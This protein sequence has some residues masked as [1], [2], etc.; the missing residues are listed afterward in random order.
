MKGI[1]FAILTAVLWGTV[2]VMEKI[3]L[4]ANMGIYNFV[5]LRSLT[6]GIFALFLSFFTDF[7]KELHQ[8]P[9][10][11]LFLITGSGIIAG[12]IAMFIYYNALKRVEASIAVPV[13]STYPLFSL[14][15]SVI[16]LG[17][18]L[19]LQ[20]TIGAFFIVAG[21]IVLSLR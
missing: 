14:I 19:T 9:L 8:L 17:E 15:F 18:K 20:N 2:P 11:N 7:L 5:I 10:K 4:S 12:F 1:I 21:V 13:A 3:A 16:F 6:V